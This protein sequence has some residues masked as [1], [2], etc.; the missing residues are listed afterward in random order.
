MTIFAFRPNWRS[1]F[2]DRL[3][4]KTEVHLS[5]NGTEQRI[6][7]RDVPRRSFTF[8]VSAFRSEFQFLDTLLAS[9]QSNV[10]TVPF[11]P[12]KSRLAAPSAIGQTIFN[13]DT[14]DRDFTLGGRIVI[15]TDPLN[16]EELPILNVTPTTVVTQTGAVR[17]W[18][19]AA[20]LIPARVC[21]FAQQISV[22]R[23]TSAVSNVSV[24]FTVE[25]VTP[26][27]PAY[28][29]TYLYNGEEVHMRKPN[30]AQDVT[31]E[32]KRLQ[33]VLDFDVGMIEV[34]D[35]AD[36]PFNVRSYSYLLRTRAAI[37]SFRAWLHERRGQI[38]PF[39]SPTWERNFEIVAP[40]LG[41]TSLTVRNQGMYQFLDPLP[42]RA[43]I[44]MRHINGAWYFR[45]INGFD[46]VAGSLEQETITLGAALGLATAASDWSLCSFLEK[47]V[48][49]SDAVE[50][51]YVTDSVAT[52]S[53]ATRSVIQ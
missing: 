33:E 18:P 47:V 17:A 2:V 41:D 46:P 7:L 14:T 25:D 43:D 42:G 31:A 24:Q 44:A 11:W 34:D 28:D 26:V 53:L 36:R 15:G 30:R 19:Q 10:V 39:W 21:R 8:E 49:N 9:Q 20:F 22:T 23:P 38:T 13:V 51:S 16:C 37:A 12:D 1:P 48:L 40:V 3:E 52:S 27:D 5:R 50:I 29:H 35:R 4:W 45:H 6:Q 32:Y